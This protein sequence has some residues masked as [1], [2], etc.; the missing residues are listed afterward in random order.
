MEKGDLHMRFILLMISGIVLII[1]FVR[2]AKKNV[3][4]ASNQK[5]TKLQIMGFVIALLGILECVIGIYCIS[6]IR[7][8][9]MSLAP[10]VYINSIVRSPYQ[11]QYWGMPTSMQQQC[12][13]FIANSFM[14]FALSA[15]CIYFRS[16]NSKWWIK[17]LKVLFCIV[18]LSF[19]KP[20]TEFQYFDIYEW[21]NTIIYAILLYFAFREKKKNVKTKEPVQVV[22]ETIIDEPTV[23]IRNNEDESRFMPQRI[24]NTSNKSEE[25]LPELKVL[26]KESDSSNMPI[27]III[28][29][30]SINNKDIVPEEIGDENCIN[31]DNYDERGIDNTDTEYNIK[32]EPTKKY[33]RFC[34]KDVN[35]QTDLFCKHCGNKL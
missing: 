33:C 9:E 3:P 32:S 24:L 20:A 26:S 18:L 21:M 16:S 23:I 10:S 30:D 2:M 1:A 31:N 27:S 5:N 13:N 15:Y 14:L 19:Y 7:F 8:P 29:N 35:Y 4:E 11:T 12:I 17:I 28:N 25:I 22:Q 34:G 6:Q